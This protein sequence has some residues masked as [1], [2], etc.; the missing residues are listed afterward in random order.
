MRAAAG[1]MPSISDML[2][3]RWSSTRFSGA[4]VH[5]LYLVHGGDSPGT[6]HVL[7]VVL[8]VLQGPPHQQGLAGLQ[9]VQGLAVARILEELYGGGAGGSR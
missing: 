1:V 9:L 3:C 8:V 4:S 5:H 6:H 7:T 2:V